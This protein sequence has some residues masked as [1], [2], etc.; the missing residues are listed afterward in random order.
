MWAN[1]TIEPQ[2]MSTWHWPSCQP[3]PG[4]LKLATQLTNHLDQLIRQES[5]K[6]H[7]VWLPL[8]KPLFEM[9]CFHMGNAHCPLRQGVKACKD[10]LGHFFPHVAQGCKDLPGWFGALFFPHLPVW[11]R[12][13]G[14]KLFGQCPYRTNTFQKG[15]SLTWPWWSCEWWTWPLSSCGSLTAYVIILV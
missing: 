9:C 8:E 6:S 15:A 1:W 3:P 11:Q 13:G 14:L 5:T 4:G 10:G 7:R 12:G 2:P